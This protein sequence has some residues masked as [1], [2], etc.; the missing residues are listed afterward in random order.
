MSNYNA[1][2]NDKYYQAFLS[3]TSR[4]LS[5]ESISERRSEGFTDVLIQRYNNYIEH[6]EPFYGSFNSLQKIKADQEI[7]IIRQK[8]E[9]CYEKLEIKFKFPEKNFDIIDTK[10]PTVEED[11][12]QSQFLSADES[13]ITEELNKTLIGEQ[14]KQPTSSTSQ[15]KPEDHIKTEDTSPKSATQKPTS[16]VSTMDE[17]QQKFIALAAKQLHNV[18]SGDPLELRAFINSIK[19]LKTIGGATLHPLLKTFVLT[20]LSGKAL[21]CVPTEPADVDAIVT[22]LETHIKPENSKVIEGKMMALKADTTKIS[23]F[24]K[25]AEK[26]A[27]ALQ[28]TLIVEGI[29]QEK[30]KSMALDKTVEMCRQTA[31][32]NLVRS[33]MASSSF[34]DPQEAIA[35]FVVESATDAKEKQIFRFSPQKN[36][37]GNNRNFFRPRNNFNWRNANNYNSNWQNNNFN[38]QN[39]RSNNNNWRKNRGRNRNRFSNN[40]TYSDRYI[41]VSNSGNPDDP[42]GDRRER[43]MNEAQVT[44]FQRVTEN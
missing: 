42:S 41:R 40:N 35:K 43:E 6:L 14:I 16:R 25:E 29:T 13:S 24:T 39:G 4:I 5:P 17:D 7:K 21:E 2:K 30:A 36:M 38:N 18:Y 44:T 33:V 37:S 28:R 20:K 3:E 23:D 1:S 9:E 19:L 27:E 10:Q 31:K 15:V 12:N 11:L 34:K 26:L 22:A 8:L 32:S